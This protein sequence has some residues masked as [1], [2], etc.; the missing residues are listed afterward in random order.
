MVP[1]AYQ[2]KSRRESMSELPAGLPVPRRSRRRSRV[3]R[4]NMNEDHIRCSRVRCRWRR[5]WSGR[6]WKRSGRADVASVKE[7]EWD[8]LLRPVR[9]LFLR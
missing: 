7:A 1:L 2:E 5:F 8:E 9:A 6:R 4:R 3:T